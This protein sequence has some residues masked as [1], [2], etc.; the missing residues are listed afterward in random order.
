MDY[1]ISNSIDTRY[2][3]LMLQLKCLKTRDIVIRIVNYLKCMEYKI[4][5]QTIS[6]ED[7]AS[8]KKNIAIIL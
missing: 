1:I 3:F 5:S 7:K 2:S 8:D 6:L 4:H